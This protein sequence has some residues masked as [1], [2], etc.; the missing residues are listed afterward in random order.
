MEKGGITFMLLFLATILSYGQDGGGQSF[1]FENQLSQRVSLP[2][3]PEA[4]EFTRYGDVGANLY[5]GAPTIQV[6]IYTHKGRE[7]DLP[8]SLSYD[9][10]G[11]KVNQLPTLTGLGWNL[12]VGGRISRM[13]NG[14]PDDRIFAYSSGAYT[15]WYNLGV[16]NKMLTY[17][18]SDYW[19]SENSGGSHNYSSH[20]QA[21]TY[22]DF[23][24]KVNKQEYETQP[25]YYSL[26]VMGLNEVFALDLNT[27]QPFSLD[28][29]ATTITTIG[30]VGAEGISGFTVKDESGTTYTF[31]VV[32]Q[33]ERVKTS[34]TGTHFQYGQRVRFNSTWYLTRIVS[35]TGKDI[36]DF[37]YADYIDN[38]NESY[39]DGISEAVTTLASTYEASSTSFSYASTETTFHNRKVLDKIK[40]NNKVI[41]DATHTNNISSGPDAGITKINIYNNGNS[42]SG[43]SLSKSY[44][45]N[46]DYFKTT[47]FDNPSANS[48][49]HKVRLKL[50]G[51][52]IYDA[53]NTNKEQEYAF[54][55]NDAEALAPLGSLAQDYLGYYNGATTNTSL[56]PPASSNYNF[57][58]SGGA[59]RNPSFNASNNG[60]LERIIYPTGGSTVFEYEQ[61]RTRI[62][63]PETE[64]NY[65]Q[66]AAI[67]HNPSSLPTPFSDQC[68]ASS[69]EDFI[70]PSVIS[71]TFQVDFQEE[72]S[73][74]LEYVRNGT[75]TTGLGIYSTINK[76]IIVVALPDANTSYNW[77]DLFDGNCQTLID[78]NQIIW[79]YEENEPAAQTSFF[80]NQGYYQ[81]FVASYFLGYT[82]TVTVEGPEASTV[83]NYIEENKAGLRI[84]SM[85]DYTSNEV[86][87]KEK[88]Y[89]YLSGRAISDPIFEYVTQETFPNAPASQDADS[90]SLPDDYLMLHRPSQPINGDKQHMAY[91]SVREIVVNYEN[92]LESLDKF[93]RFLTPN[94]SQ[95]IYKQGTYQI[96][97]AGG[98]FGS[99]NYSKY[100]YF[101]SL[102][103]ES[104][105]T[106]SR[107]IEYNTPE[108]HN[109][110][111]TFGLATHSIGRN[112]NRYPVITQRDGGLWH[113]TLND[114]PSN[115]GAF[116][117]GG[118]NLYFWVAPPEC[119]SNPTYCTPE[120]ARLSLHKTGAFGN[121]GGDPK[122]ETTLQ[123]GVEQMVTYT[124]TPGDY[125]YPKTITTTNSEGESRVITH[126]YPHED[127]SYSGLVNAHMYSTPVITS[128]AEGGAL[129]STVKT[130]FTSQELPKKIFT[131]KGNDLL[132][133]RMEFAKY[134]FKNPRQ[135]QQT[136]GEST[137]LIWGY[138]DRYIVARISN[139]LYNSLN[140]SLISTIRT[141]SNQQDQT[142]LLAALQNLQAS[143]PDDAQMSYYTHYPN[144]GVRTMTDPSGY[145][146]EYIYDDFQRLEKVVDNYGK[147]VEK[148][149]YNYRELI[150]PGD[151]N[152]DPD[153]QP[154][155]SSAV[156][157]VPNNTTP[158]STIYYSGQLGGFSGG[159]GPYTFQWFRKVVKFGETAG[160]YV[161][162]ATTSSNSF[163]FQYDINDADYC[164]SG[165]G[166]IQFKCIATDSNGDPHQNFS[167]Q[168]TLYCT[169]DQQ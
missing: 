109:N 26:N 123:D 50:D 118:E 19:F 77:A 32:D 160:D 24:D 107:E 87:A 104:T 25:D 39:S 60:I 40:H 54:F 153:P 145:R 113:I 84:K 85:K 167:T 138:N 33:T 46:Y 56:I 159:E 90:N 162:F 58:N 42:T 47:A 34:D 143:L 69:T 55:Y 27:K 155:T 23:L 156:T 71:T 86:L 30:G 28:N 121:F 136:D 9:A 14:L 115:V 82:K 81:L 169:I 152:P 137:A 101:G 72:G 62:A 74:N 45:F 129:I 17:S 61:A 16:K 131:A 15:S 52:D 63:D 73:H 21:L 4:F 70:S 29:P 127:P 57:P 48:D 125:R 1:N 97:Q 12:N 44:R 59:N 93:Y 151:P 6:P 165:G 119:T 76:Q 168:T 68:N 166:S 122:V 124:Y 5:T 80:L 2:Q 88:Q 110:N 7:L 157:F 146:M 37:I 79:V 41:V 116:G 100:P 10:S 139:I 114:V 111:R 75:A 83:I 144:I 103:R 147:V 8:I 120:F 154:M 158:G 106:S 18:D 134:A 161:S 112:S 36:Y 105:A 164:S 66:K 20:S 22:F 142:G 49:I 126:T 78:P 163:N 11:I 133:E 135:V 149:R 140:S 98:S 92:P 53:T 31:A 96:P 65:V 95:N 64:I 108:V 67:T 91:S 148:Y 117:F 35:P 102:Q 141:E 150:P 128:Q 51:I 38:R 89:T 13:V 94:Q 130:T 3:A 132:E 99:T 43:T